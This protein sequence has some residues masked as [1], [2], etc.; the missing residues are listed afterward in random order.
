ME[1][2]VKLNMFVRKVI[3]RT[4]YRVSLLLDKLKKK[5]NEIDKDVNDLIDLL[6]YKKFNNKEDAL[7]FRDELKSKGSV[8]VYVG[9]AKD[10]EHFVFYLPENVENINRIGLLKNKIEKLILFL[11]K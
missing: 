8:A 6:Q 7:K 9:G 2:E 5:A 10:D 1:P 3:G 4:N 11:D